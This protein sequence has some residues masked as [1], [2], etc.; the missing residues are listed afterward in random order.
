MNILHKYKPL[1]GWFPYPSQYI[2]QIETF[3]TNEGS[4]EEQDTHVLPGTL[5]P[6]VPQFS[7]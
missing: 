1:F 4:E 7:S 6:K 3:K 2:N 5:H